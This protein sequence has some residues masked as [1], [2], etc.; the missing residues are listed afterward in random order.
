MGF[1][2]NGKGE[3][4]FARVWRNLDLRQLRL[5]VMALVAATAACATTLFNIWNP[6]QTGQDDIIRL[7]VTLAMGISF[8]LVP[9]LIFDHPRDVKRRALATILFAVLYC[10]FAWVSRD[11]PSI[12]F[13]YKI[14]QGYVVSHLLVSLTPYLR[15]RFQKNSSS[16]PD[17]LAEK[18]FW[19]EN[20][21]LLN[22]F[23]MAGVQSAFLLV[24]TFAALFSLH[25]LFG[26][27]IKTEVYSTVAVLL[28]SIGSVLL[29]VGS[30]GDRQQI[31]EPP[32]VLKRLVRTALT[33]LAII[34]IAI[35]YAY[36]VKIGVAREWPRGGIGFLV[37]GLAFIVTLSYV[38]MRP[39]AAADDFGPKLKRFWNYSFRLM[40]APVLLLMLGLGRRVSE[41]GWTEQRAALG[42]LALWM[43]GLSLYYWNPNRRSLVGIPLSL[44]LVFLI[45]WFGP[46]SPSF[47]DQKSQGARLEKLL[48]LERPKM[49]RAQ[50]GEVNTLLR[51]LC[52]SHGPEVMAK[53]ARVEIPLERVQESNR[54]LG[55]GAR[56]YARTCHDGNDAAA[57]ESKGHVS[58]ALEKLGVEKIDPGSTSAS[59]QDFSFRRTSQSPMFFDGVEFGE[60]AF[61]SW[62]QPQ[63]DAIDK[64]WIYASSGNMK[65]RFNR[66]ISKLEWSPK[67]NI[68]HDL[69]LTAV[70]KYVYADRDKLK[71][72]NTS[73]AE[74]ESK[75]LRIKA[76][77]AGRSLEIQVRLM[78]FKEDDPLRPNS[79]DFTALMK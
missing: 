36:V 61:N 59:K 10:L 11:W 67:E 31:I 51:H 27:D 18:Y 43:L 45:T 12:Y 3:N 62:D 25:Q 71:I 42:F 76:A 32:E 57:T 6:P 14:L 54:F 8:F 41:Y 1:I 72:E 73:Y 44:T 15:R 74:A 60:V 30:L 75:G 34:Y 38:I 21:F 17:D 55:Y 58:A 28:I 7:I 19:S 50:K 53:I 16:S 13:F 23:Q 56:N 78:T 4:M 33:P 26:L 52:D 5:H 2:S 65:F 64:D 35:L 69:D 24:G 47:I 37:S 77:A 48:A 68:W 9:S 66:K 79:I 49:T 63:P 20:W 22:R 40:I 29:F 70:A 46:L 39:L